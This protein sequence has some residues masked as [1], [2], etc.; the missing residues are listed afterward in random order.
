M[1]GWAGRVCVSCLIVNSYFV[2]NSE[3]DNWRAELRDSY[4]RLKWKL[5]LF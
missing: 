4:L 5:C 1:S 2:A 3:L